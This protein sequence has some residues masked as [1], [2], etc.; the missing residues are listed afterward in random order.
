LDILRNTNDPDVKMHFASFKGGALLNEYQNVCPR[1][2]LLGRTMPID[3]RTIIR[4]RDIIVREKIDVIH[5]HLTIDILYAQLA[6]KATNAKHIHTHHGYDY[7]ISFKDLLV[8]RLFSPFLDAHVFV[9][10][11]LYDHYYSKYSTHKNWMIIENGVDSRK[12]TA[13]SKVPSN[14]RRELNLDSR[15]PLLGMVGNFVNTGRDQLTI[16]KALKA[17]HDSGDDFHFIFIGRSNPQV[18]EIYE[19]CVQYCNENLLS[20]CVHFLGSRTDIPSILS[21]LDLFVYASNHDTFGIAVIEAMLAEVP[22]FVNDL[23]IFN[24][25][26]KCGKYLSMYPTKDS[27]KLADMIHS[28]LHDTQA[29]AGIA[30]CAKA[31][32]A[33]KYSIDRNVSDL[34]RSYRDIVNG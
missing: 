15:V 3:F 18:P 4:L 33:E 1:V 6:K 24:I 13:A 11:P 31:Y 29:F 22:V 14:I 8:E 21:E 32:A 7:G 19:K 12:I 27:M 20:K 26:G 16:C 9:S 5:T 17:V 28:F 2:Y 30:H 10:R 25:I 23:E 34:L